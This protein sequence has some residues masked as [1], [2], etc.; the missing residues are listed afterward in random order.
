VIDA[1]LNPD[2]SQVELDAPQLAGNTRFALSVP[3]KR[4]F[5]LE[6]ADVVGQTLPDDS[7]DNHSLAAFYTRAITDPDWGLRAT[8]RGA[9][10]EATAL[11]LRDKGG[12]VVLRAGAF[13][14]AAHAQPR[15]SQASFVRGRVQWG[16]LGW[17]GLASRRDYGA[18]QL[19]ELV[20]SDAV[21][22]ASESD[23]VRGHVLL[24]ATTLG[25][26][27]DDRAQRVARQS[28]HRVW[29]SG[30][31]RDADWGG[32]FNFEDISPRF[33]NDNGFVSQTGIRRVTGFVYRRLGAQELVGLPMYE[34][35]AQVHLQ[36]TR[37]LDDP[38]MGV[39]AG[40]VVDELVQ[41]GFWFSSARNSNVWGHIGL[42]R[43]RAKS[44]GTLHA[45]RT[46]LVGFEV[47]PGEF[48]NL[49]NAEL[50]WGRRLDVDA[51][52]VGTG[53]QGQIEAKWR[54]PLPAGLALEWEQR[55]GLG[56]VEN[57]QGQRAFTD[58][59]AQSLLVLHVS[60]NESVRL[61]SQTLHFDRRAEPGLA[62]QSS[63]ERNLA[64]MLQH[65]IGLTRV[66]SLG[67]NRRSAQPEQESGREIFFKAALAY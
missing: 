67:L 5:F 34:S 8:W 48:F 47:S 52:R 13:G 56:Y 22:R 20:G 53:L 65:R 36:Q 42:D 16:E 46:V 44:G 64:L 27:A 32:N 29:L 59:S 51:D 50:E 31:H 3:E 35:E 62:A 57:P 30:R 58:R 39:A 54:L 37:T 2:F 66:I 38:L 18:G 43:H 21:W 10:A 55:L 45:T 11:S 40:Q 17:A 1:T 41:P 6:S 33:A 14:T 19:S 63:R 23:L 24:S 26:D 15:D 28:G 25:F 12:G 61:I 4:P 60:A 9:D 49:L 7:G